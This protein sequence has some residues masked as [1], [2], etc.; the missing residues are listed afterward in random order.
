MNVLNTDVLVIGSGPSGLA[1]AL[2]AHRNGA[3]TVI[4]DSFARAGGQYWM[5]SNYGL[6][7][8]DRQM[9][10]GANFISNS[11]NLGIK[12]ITDAEVW[13]ILPKY[14]VFIQQGSRDSIE[15]TARALVI[16]T[17]AHD[18]VMPFTGWTLPGVMTAGA[19]QR[20]VKMYGKPPGDKI[21]L[22]GSG[23]FLW[24]VAATIVKAGGKLEAMVESSSNQF[25]LF[26]LIGRHPSRWTETR[27]LLSPV[28]RSGVQRLNGY[29]ID[30]AQGEDRIEAVKLR[31]VSNSDRDASQELEMETDCLLVSH[32][33]RPITEI[34]A[35]LR[36]EHQF[37]TKKGGW[38]C[39]T[40]PET[41]ATSIDNVYAAGEVTGVT[42]AQSA[43]IEGALA[44]LGVSEKLGFTRN[45][46]ER[47]R[48]R[49][50]KRQL[51]TARFA[52]GLAE[53]FELNTN[54]MPRI[55]DN[56]L[57][58]RCED[59][60]WGDVLKSWDDGAQNLQAVKYWTRLGMGRC[61]GRICGV[62]V[63][64]LLANQFDL[65]PRIFG[66]NHPRLPLRPVTVNVVHDA[67]ARKSL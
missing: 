44:G 13:G 6:E 17:G 46:I 35:L 59:V 57:V 49:L 55:D 3:N 25:R 52:D 31:Q 40:D 58:C 26:S 48:A 23:V 47:K 1:A 21:V 11:E 5:Q 50:M 36:C 14:R 20:Y 67:L 27:R 7:R 53:L 28:L 9:Q 19:G 10:E 65:D 60:I 43:L 64:R 39:K 32:G 33:F 56:T 45:G 24:A 41:G 42:G 12:T 38:Y 15:I 8:N 22:A 18:F 54:S 16:C 66:F 4:V 30:Y 29:R 62:A 51:R 63:S 37:D 61:Q 2:E 34:T